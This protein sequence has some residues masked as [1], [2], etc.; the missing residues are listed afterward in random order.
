MTTALNQHAEPTLFQYVTHRIF[1]KLLEEELKVPGQ[2]DTG[3]AQTPMTWEE[4]NAL[5]YVTG[6]VCHKVQSN[7]AK[8]KVQNKEEMM[9]F[10]VELS[11][12][13]DDENRGTEEWTNRIDRGGLWHINDNAYLIFSIFEE[14]IRKHLKVSALKSLNDTIKKKIVDAILAN[15]ELLFQWTLLS[16]NADDAV[17]MDILKR[18]CELYLTVRGFA[19]S[20]SCMELYKDHNKKSLQKSKAIR[21]KIAIASNEDNSE[22]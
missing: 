14:E 16:A 15:E 9:L 17:G 22:D 3:E 21:K 12:D 1:K 19:F 10:F 13:E 8:S 11:G 6:Y 18:I 20:S 5:R 4:E 7:I 2:E